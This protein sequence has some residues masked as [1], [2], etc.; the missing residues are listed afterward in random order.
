MT[1]GPPPPGSPWATR[2]PDAYPA[3]W[4]D[5]L[6]LTALP[7]GFARF[8]TADESALF[9]GAI[10]PAELDART[11]RRALHTHHL[12]AGRGAHEGPVG[13]RAVPVSGSGHQ[14]RSSP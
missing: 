6:G 10:A 5:A 13:S 8:A 3:E 1:T 14:D 11:V 7:A 2:G 9:A 12:R 4:L